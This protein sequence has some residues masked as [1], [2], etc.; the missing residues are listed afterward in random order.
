MQKFH[1]KTNINAKKNLTGSSF[2][3]YRTQ[4]RTYKKY[5]HFF[6]SFNINDYEE[7]GFLNNIGK[8]TDTKTS[9]KIPSQ[10]SHHWH[11]SHTRR[12]ATA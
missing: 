12:F 1:D 3:D 8:I 2:I 9:E 7:L 4:P 6:L 5:P 10:K 11:Y